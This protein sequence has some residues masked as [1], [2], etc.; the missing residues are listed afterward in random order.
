MCREMLVLEER[1]LACVEVKGK[2]EGG[3]LT[4]PGRE[5]VRGKNVWICPRVLARVVV[6]VSEWERDRGKASR[7]TRRETRRRARAATNSV[8]TGLSRQ[9]PLQE[10]QIKADLSSQDLFRALPTGS[11]DP[12]A[13]LFPTVPRSVGRDDKEPGVET[14]PLLSGARVLVCNAQSHLLAWKRSAPVI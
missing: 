1:E 6:H 9:S 5:C 4:K 11:L 13:I 14:G 2:M 10:T 12:E 8:T 3:R 7:Y